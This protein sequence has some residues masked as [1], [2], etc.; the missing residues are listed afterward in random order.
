LRYRREE[1]TER[2]QTRET[3]EQFGRNKIFGLKVFA[4][5]LRF[6]ILF[7]TKIFS[8]ETLGMEN[9]GGENFCSALPE[10]R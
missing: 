2:K 1:G 10:K 9:S 6:F 5:E 7:M 3:L 4:L 8:P